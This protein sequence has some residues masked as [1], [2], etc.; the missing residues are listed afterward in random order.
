VIDFGR[1]RDIQTS[2]AKNQQAAAAARQATAHA[3]PPLA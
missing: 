1:G 3:V 2:Q